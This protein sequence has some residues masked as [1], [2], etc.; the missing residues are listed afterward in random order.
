MM[1][2]EPLVDKEE[3]RADKVGQSQEEWNKKH[4]QNVLNRLCQV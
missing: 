1:L 4:D 3:E 2:I